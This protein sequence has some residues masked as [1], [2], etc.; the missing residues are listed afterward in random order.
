MQYNRLKAAWVWLT[1]MKHC[2]G[3]GIQSPWAYRFVRYVVNEHAPYY[4][5]KRLKDKKPSD[6]L[7]TKRGRLLLRLANYW[8]PE[9]VYGPPLGEALVKDYLLAGCR[10]ATFR[11]NMTGK[12]TGRWMAIVKTDD[13]ELLA[14]YADEQAMMVLA[15]IGSSKEGKRLWRHIVDDPRATATFDLYWC[16]IALFDPKRIKQNYIVNF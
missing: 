8:Q 11:N 4:A 16:G 7:T 2:R 1:R 3:F 6:W 13:Y 5:Y 14:S 12:P 9:E 10:K 15:D